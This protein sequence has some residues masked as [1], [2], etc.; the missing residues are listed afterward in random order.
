M[1]EYVGVRATTAWQD[2]ER[3]LVPHNGRLLTST[4]VRVGMEPSPAS[5]ERSAVR[6]YQWQYD[7]IAVRVYDALLDDELV[8]IRL[9]DPDAGKVDD[10][11]LI[12]RQGAHGYQ[13]K[14]AEAPG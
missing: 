13:F 14:S 11:V 9:T 10:L 4:R 12:S 7:H 2:H 1:L 8:E 6:G 3:C 5:G